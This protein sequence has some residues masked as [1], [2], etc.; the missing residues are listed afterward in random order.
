MES[1]QLKFVLKLLGQEGYRA[2]LNEKLNPGKTTASEREKICRSLTEQGI[3]ASA[4]EVKKFEITSAGKA[5]LQQDISQLPLSESQ[6]LVLKAAVQKAISPSDVKKVPAAECQTVIQ[7]LAAKGLIKIKAERITEVWLTEAGYNYL[8]DE[9]TVKGTNPAISLNLLQNYLNFMRK[10]LH[11]NQDS[12]L[13]TEPSAAQV[14]IP[15]A[16][17]TEQPSDEQ[18]LQTI[19]Q[20]DQALNSENYLPLFHLR[21]HFQSVSRDELDQSLYRLQRQD[22]IELHS[23]IEAIHYTEAQIQAGIYQ[24]SSSPLFFVSYRSSAD[25]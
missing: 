13:A 19:Q 7:D 6:L 25:D 11:R 23:L 14:A 16:S 2:P 17:S 1:V 9:C 4:R 22:K 5:L 12:A 20:L 24:D 21:Q 10:A 8:R 3:L 15:A 18:V